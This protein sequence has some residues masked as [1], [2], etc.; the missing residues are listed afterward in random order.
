MTENAKI[1]S[2][3]DVITPE[4]AR[5]W[6]EKSQG[7]RAITQAKVDQYARD[8]RLGKWLVTGEAIQFGA[9]GRLLNGHHR[10]LACIQSDA[11][12]T[13][14][15]VRNLPDE[16]AVMDVIDTGKK[17]T[18]G[19]ALQIQGEVDA[20]SLAGIVTM[21]WRYEQ[22]RLSGAEW[23]THA[24][25]I[26]WLAENP[27]VRDAVHV[28]ALV[29]KHLRSQRAPTGA[30]YY[31]NARIDADAAGEFWEMA[32]SGE[33]LEPESAILAY[34]RWVIGTLARR[35]KPAPKT[36]L[37]YS[38]KAMNHW[39]A[40]RKVRLLSLKPNEDLPETW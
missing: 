13:S 37:G 10:L 23:P 27:G 6:I 28:S 40:G 8:I 21:C 12:F 31:L 16:Q 32:A 24:E 15:V 39:R 20:N 9:S 18:L 30:A 4:M 38:L 34:R 19:N 2:R 22:H 29:Y 1:H 26:E 33:G 3:V 36:W 35:D 17:R 5:K 25:A 14:L 11:S 7:N